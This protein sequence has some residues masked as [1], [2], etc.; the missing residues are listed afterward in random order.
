M[1]LIVR[2]NGHLYNLLGKVWGSSLM[3][4]GSFAIPIPVEWQ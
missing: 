1:Y 2:C 3:D 4:Q